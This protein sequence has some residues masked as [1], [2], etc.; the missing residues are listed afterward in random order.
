M[1]EKPLTQKTSATLLKL[2]QAEITEYHIYQKIAAA[3]TD[4]H[5]REILTRIAEQENEHYLIWKKYTGRDVA[6]DVYR[7]WYYYLLARILGITFAIKL[8]EGIEKRAQHVYREIG[9]IIPEVKEIVAHEEANERE[10]IGLLDEE[11]LRYVGSVVLGLNDALV[12]FTGTLAGLT[13]ALQNS[14]VIAMA[15]LITGV[16][17]S[18]SMGASEYL[19]QKSGEGSQNAGKAALYTGT[20]YI[21]TVFLLVL[22]FLLF[23]NPYVALPITLGCAILVIFLFTFY[24]S[25]AKDL[26]FVRRF[27]EM[28]AISMGIAAISFVIGLIIRMVLHVDL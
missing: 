28:V 15:G 25:I 14:Q 18:L 12:E 19:S 11:R 9:T 8:M 20:A 7:I 23:S 6:P 27:L 24:I 16:A 21:F 17:A 5:N 10:L 4:P 1:M 26:P 22:P 2:Q 3:T 13:F